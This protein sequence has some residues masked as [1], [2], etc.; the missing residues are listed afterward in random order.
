MESR[1]LH[2]FQ[3]VRVMVRVAIVATKHEP[4]IHT[5]KMV[6]KSHGEIELVEARLADENTEAVPTV[7]VDIKFLALMAIFL[8]QDSEWP[9]TLRD[10]LAFLNEVLNGCVRQYHEALA[11]LNSGSAQ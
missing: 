4:S 8:K 5:R 2:L 7:A 3:D 9:D 10:W 6:D 1:N 11:A